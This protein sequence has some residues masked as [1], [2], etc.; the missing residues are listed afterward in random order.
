MCVWV[1]RN[2]NKHSLST[3]QGENLFL[4]PHSKWAPRFAFVFSLKLWNQLSWTRL[5]NWEII[6]DT[7]IP[8]KFKEAFGLHMLRVLS[9]LTLRPDGADQAVTALLIVLR[10]L[11]CL[12]IHIS[13]FQGAG[14]TLQCWLWGIN[15]SIK[16]R[17]HLQP[18]PS[19]SFLASLC[20]KMH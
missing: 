5:I 10:S 11:I 17:S 3:L 4:F 14:T 2:K 12:S 15:L 1:H 19:S 8:S 16:H 20:K 18:P 6:E 13:G 7:R 9:T